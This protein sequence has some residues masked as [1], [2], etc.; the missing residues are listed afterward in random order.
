MI[1]MEGNDDEKED[2]VGNGGVDGGDGVVM[3]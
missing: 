1:T 3:R 2:D